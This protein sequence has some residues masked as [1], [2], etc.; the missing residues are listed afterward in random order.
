MH[1][2]LPTGCAE[3]AG[4]GGKGITHVNACKIGRDY[5]REKTSEGEED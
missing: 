4:E 2:L 5:E 1:L 3:E